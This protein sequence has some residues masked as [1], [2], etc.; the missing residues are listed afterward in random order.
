MND[1][2]FIY[3]GIIYGNSNF[4]FSEGYLT[5]TEFTI[6]VRYGKY[7]YFI[8]KQNLSI[9]L[10]KL[11]TEGFSSEQELRVWL[12]I[13]G[14]ETLHQVLFDF[15][16]AYLSSRQAYLTAKRLAQGMIGI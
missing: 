9:P 15:G 8:V 16:V 4:A 13:E 14:K 12:D 5:L 10:T 3:E 11:G 1:N 7:G 2:T 6:P